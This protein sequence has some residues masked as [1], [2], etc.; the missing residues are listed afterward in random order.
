MSTVAS[1][2]ATAIVRRAFRVLEALRELPGSRAE[3]IAASTGD[4]LRLVR[5]TL[6][7]LCDEGYVVSID[8]ES[9]VLGYRMFRFADDA[10]RRSA[11]LR[12]VA[13]P[14]LEAASKAFGETVNLLILEGQLAVYIDQVPGKRG[15][16]VHR[17]VG[18][19]LPLHA[20]AS[21]KVLMA[22]RPDWRNLVGPLPLERFTD[23]TITD[24][25]KLEIE[26]RDVRRRGYAVEAEEAESGVRCVACPVMNG[27][28]QVAATVS[29]S[30]PS[31]RVE[32]RENELGKLL[33]QHTS[34]ISSALGYVAAPLDSH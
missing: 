32:G 31:Q 18:R 2:S 9:H 22:H 15:V 23:T 16:Q 12:A 34:A 26:L 6:Q 30:A 29:V 13:R 5:K 11:Y 3:E 24:L 17:E 14:H 33:L 1:T 20:T 4:E 8:G 10:R 27:P 19:G 7:T 25:G 21:G 28:Q